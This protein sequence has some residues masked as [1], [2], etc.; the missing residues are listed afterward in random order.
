[1]ADSS[2]EEYSLLTLS[3]QS[4]LLSSCSS[5]LI[6]HFASLDKMPNM[7]NIGLLVFGSHFQHVRNPAKCLNVT[8]TVTQV[9]YNIAVVDMVL[10]K[11]LFLLI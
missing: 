2:S 10:F 6:F 4:L 7:G 1:M 8:S 9:S 11:Y 3:L 5:E